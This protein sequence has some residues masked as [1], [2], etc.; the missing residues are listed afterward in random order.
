MSSRHNSRRN[1][2]RGGKLN[3]LSGDVIYTVHHQPSS[4][5]SSS[6]GFP[7]NP[8]RKNK[9][10]LTFP[11]FKKKRCRRY[12]RD[13]EAWFVL[14]ETA[15]AR[16]RRIIVIIRDR[17][18]WK[19]YHLTS[20]CD[21]ARRDKLLAAFSGV[22]SRLGGDKITSFSWIFRT[23]PSLWISYLQSFAY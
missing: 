21:V 2:S 11:H 22:S 18:N 12:M 13:S 8:S 7:R 20:H 10:I 4:E 6:V 1:S 16:D 23:F 14:R 9:N 5:A 17:I 15:P 3:F 19:V